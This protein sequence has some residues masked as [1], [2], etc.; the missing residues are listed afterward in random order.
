V[1]IIHHRRGYIPDNHCDTILFVMYANLTFEIADDST[2]FTI[3]VYQ[4]S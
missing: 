1:V 3:L 4:V 2:V